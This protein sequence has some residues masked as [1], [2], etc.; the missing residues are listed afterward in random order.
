MSTGSVWW[1][2]L[3]AV[4]GAAGALIRW[5]V[6]T[7]SVRRGDGAFAAT[8]AVNAA[9]SFGLGVM[10]ALHLSVAPAALLATGL[11]GGLSTFST[12]AVELATRP[13]RLR[14]TLFGSV[15][16]LAAFALGR[17]LG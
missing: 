11:C 16:A 2:A 5:V 1:Y 15:T 9:G 17:T 7:W 13:G 3:V 10:T 14:S 8:V 6:T 12:L 4:G